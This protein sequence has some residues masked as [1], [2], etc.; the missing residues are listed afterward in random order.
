MPGGEIMSVLSVNDNKAEQDRVYELGVE[1]Y[2]NQA[3][4]CTPALP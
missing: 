4:I 3:R 2:D 1:A